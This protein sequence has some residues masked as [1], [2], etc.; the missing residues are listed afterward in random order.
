[1]TKRGRYVHLWDRLNAIARI[2]AKEV[3]PEKIAAEL[4]IAIDEVQQW[5][6]VHGEE[7]RDPR[8]L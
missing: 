7:L 2:R 3:T 6:F 1:M 4:G 5:M 8:S